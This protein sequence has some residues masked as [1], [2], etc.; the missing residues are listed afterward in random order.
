MSAIIQP[1]VGAYA[2]PAMQETDALLRSLQGRLAAAGKEHST[3]WD[4]FLYNGGTFAV[5]A[6]TTAATFLPAEPTSWPWLPKALTGF[7]TFWIALERALSFGSRWRFHRELRRCYQSLVDRID[8]Y[9][10]T[11]SL[12]PAEEQQRQLREIWDELRNLQQREGH[13]PGLPSAPAQPAGSGNAN[14]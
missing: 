3:W 4:S 6:A 7:A 1:T 5:L 2:P 13:I 8:L 9:L 10:A 14:P 11:R 12:V